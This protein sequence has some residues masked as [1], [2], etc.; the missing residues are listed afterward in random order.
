MNS[1]HLGIE[2]LRIWAMFCILFGHLMYHGG[3]I[4][5]FPKDSVYQLFLYF[6]ASIF[7]VPCA[8]N[9]FAIVSGYMGYASFAKTANA[10][11][12]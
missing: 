5:T 1:R 8:L 9:C 4:E 3:V 12:G 10:T 11:G 7:N 6:V 2:A